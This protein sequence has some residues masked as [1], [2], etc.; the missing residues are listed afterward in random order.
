MMA[1]PLA[2][3]TPLEIEGRVDGMIGKVLSLLQH[4]QPD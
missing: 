2:N 4:G 3:L 1:H